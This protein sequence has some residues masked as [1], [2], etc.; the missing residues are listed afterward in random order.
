MKSKGLMCKECPYYKRLQL[1]KKYMPSIVHEAF[2]S[3]V[4]SGIIETKVAYV[5]KKLLD[6][7]NDC[8]D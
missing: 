8:S 7:D 6:E 5:L 2:T 3:A 4:N 1:I